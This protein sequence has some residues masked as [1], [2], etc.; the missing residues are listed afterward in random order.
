ML[1]RHEYFPNLNAA[2]YRDTSP[3]DRDY[4]C[5]AWAAGLNDVWWDPAEPAEPD[6][7]N[8]WPENAPR[9]YKVSSLIVAFESLG[10]VAC[11]NALQED[12]IEKIAIYADDD[13][14]MHAA[15]Q[16][17]NGK[18]TSKIGR[19]EDIEHDALE[20]LVGPAYGQVAVFMKR[21]L[22]P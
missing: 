16:L 22:T 10:F 18:W 4:N 8:F 2:N 20:D 14:Y 15:R 6:E 13:E 11:T 17:K 9:N 1:F 12:G 3:A 5:I 7:N 21:N 19:Y